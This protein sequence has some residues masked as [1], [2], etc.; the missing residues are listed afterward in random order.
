M[1]YQIIGWTDYDDDDYP[2]HGGITAYIRRLI[3]E[4]I[5]KNEYFFGGDMHEYYCPVLNDG[6]LVSFSWRG[7][8]GVM[9]E[10]WNVED[11]NGYAYM[12]GY[13]NELMDKD[14]L[15]YP[16]GSVR[17]KLIVPKESLA[18]TFEVAAEG[19]LFERVKS[20]KENITLH[21]DP[22]VG[23]RIDVGDFI[24]FTCG[25]QTVTA[26]VD[27]IEYFEPSYDEFMRQYKTT[28]DDARFS[29]DFSGAYQ[30]YR[31]EELA[32]HRGEVTLRLRTQ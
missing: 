29:Y 1:K 23:E 18:E 31:A 8:G 10:A 6:T 3:V 27:D 26:Q 14:R 15:K 17:E 25:D 11:T 7:W 19:E 22:D 12:F 24:K 20:G 5:R 28:H 16:K 21:F 13:M 32:K 4:E 9:A 30:K 2:E